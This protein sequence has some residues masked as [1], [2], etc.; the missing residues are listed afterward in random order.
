MQLKLFYEVVVKHK[1]TNWMTSFDVYMCIAKQ[2][3]SYLTK[4][5]SNISGLK[6]TLNSLNFNWVQNI[7]KIDFFSSK[8]VYSYTI[9]YLKFQTMLDAVQQFLKS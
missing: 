5:I 4:N 7:S 2:P 9:Y 8:F 1:R 3:M 6:I